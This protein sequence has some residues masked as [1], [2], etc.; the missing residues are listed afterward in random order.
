MSHFF[1]GK[2][3]K[4]WVSDDEKLAFSLFFQLEIQLLMYTENLKILVPTRTQNLSTN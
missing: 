1:L 4:P 2:E 3:V